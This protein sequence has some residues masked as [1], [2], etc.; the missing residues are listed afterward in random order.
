MEHTGISLYHMR[1]ERWKMSNYLDNNDIQPHL[2]QSWTTLAANRVPPV[3]CFGS[4]KVWGFNSVQ[5][6]T[7]N[8]ASDSGMKPRAFLTAWRCNILDQTNDLSK[9]TRT[10]G[11]GW[12][13]SESDAGLCDAPT[14][15]FSTS[16]LTSL[17]GLN[18]QSVAGL[19]ILFC[20]CPL[21]SVS[22]Q[23][24]SS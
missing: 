23:C 7:P 15:R 9:R 17:V 14:G 10:P 3:I 12:G 20:K 6:L 16:A 18:S 1:F 21:S 8:T 5:R 4:Y 11:D 19:V 22:T 24:M 2:N 13:Q